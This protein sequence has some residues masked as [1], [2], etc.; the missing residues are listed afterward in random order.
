MNTI[1]ALAPRLLNVFF[2]ILIIYYAFAIVG[3]EFLYDR[4]SKGCCNSSWYGVDLYYSAEVDPPHSL[5]D[6]NTPYV[7]YL[8]NFDNILRSYGEIETLALLLIT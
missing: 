1:L 4:V 2:L 5:N 6:T 7:Y 8:N 3:M